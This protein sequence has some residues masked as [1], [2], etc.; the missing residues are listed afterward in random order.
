MTEYEAS[1]A[2]SMPVVEGVTHHEVVI[3]GLRMHYAEAGEGPAV[4]LLHG[5]PQHWWCWRFLI[6]PLAQH[7]RVICPDFRGMGWSDGPAR[8]DYTL[9]RMST[10]VVAL[11]DHLG[12]EH[13][14]LVGHDWGLVVGYQACF[15]WPERFDHFVALAGVHL[16]SLDGAPL[17]LWFRPWHLFVIAAL[18]D[19]ALSRLGLMT[20]P[21]RAWRAHGRFTDD[22]LR[23]YTDVMDTP[24]S[25]HATRSFDRNVVLRALPHFLRTY[26]S[27]RLRVP[28]LH[29]NG[30]RDPLTIGVPHSYQKYADDMTLELV[31]S[32]GH[33][34]AEERPEWLLERMRRFLE[35]PAHRST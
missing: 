21:F 5:W 27:L 4:V 16:W 26:R 30:D 15:T 32:C 23:T 18:G 3:D 9:R 6:G 29:L 33:F 8:P 11:M 7:Y 25:R 1:P 14:D 13:A 31:P 19:L 24:R 20:R 22:E 10:D 17:R 28:T 12:I 35:A 2:V 34:I